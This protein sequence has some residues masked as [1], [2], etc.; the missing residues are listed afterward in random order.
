MA[1]R[2]PEAPVRLSVL[3]RLLDPDPALDTGLSPERSAQKFRDAV[4]RDLEWLL[5]TRRTP[6][7]APDSLPELQ[8][9]LYDFG[10]PDLTAMRLD[11]D[12][13]R[14]LVRSIENTLRL[15]EPRISS[16]RVSL[17]DTSSERR[18]IRLLIEGMLRMDPDL[19]PITFDTLLDVGSG[20]I[21][22]DHA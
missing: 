15:F 1:R 3:D 21:S 5:N 10:L 2:R 4:L 22:V 11:S 6:A 17:V 14:H 7:A 13:Q 20:E 8:R 9:S 18:Q 19:E 16:L 12:S